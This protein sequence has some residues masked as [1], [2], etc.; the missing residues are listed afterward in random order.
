MTATPWNEISAAGLPLPISSSPYGYALVESWQA[1][2][3]FIPGVPSS[4]TLNSSDSI[5]SV[6]WFSNVPPG[7]FAPPH[8]QAGMP[9]GLN[10]SLGDPHLVEIGPGF[11]TSNPISANSLASLAVSDPSLVTLQVFV[12]S[13]SAKDLSAP[14]LDSV[15]STDR[16]RLA[17]PHPWIADPGVVYAQVDSRDSAAIPLISYT[18]REF[19]SGEPPRSPAYPPPP[20]PGVESH[21]PFDPSGPPRLDLSELFL[22]A[23]RPPVES[24]PPPPG[25]GSPP[26]AERDWS[27]NSIVLPPTKSE[28]GSNLAVA[29]TTETTPTA[30]SKELPSTSFIA[31]AFP[32]SLAQAVVNQV[33]TGISQGYSAA[34]RGFASLLVSTVAPT[35]WS[36]SDLAPLTEASN[37]TRG[38]ATDQTLKVDARTRGSELLSWKSIEDAGSI[39]QALDLFLDQLSRVEH[40]S[41]E[42]ETNDDE[43]SWPLV[44]TVALVSVEV[45]RRWLGIGDRVSAFRGRGKRSRMAHSKGALAKFAGWPG[46]WSSRFP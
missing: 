5:D 46:S 39:G 31:M 8:L 12:P 29:T 20:P 38:D 6:A 10:M 23:V 19:K 27:F 37:Q 13:L 32:L 17:A 45:S 41:G 14:M 4:L 2:H 26:R 35:H 22:A 44:W 43:N 11:I 34:M 9:S 30:T 42:S 40:P 3:A 25:M 16:S 15:A 28:S 33:S 7:P 18:S 21:T 36:A 1:G 24:P